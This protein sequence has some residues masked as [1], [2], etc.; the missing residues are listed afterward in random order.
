MSGMTNTASC[1]PARG[2]RG[3]G[4]TLVQV[5]VQVCARSR[6]PTHLLQVLCTEHLRTLVYTRHTAPQGREGK[7]WKNGGEGIKS[8]GFL[9]TLTALSK[10]K[11]SRG[12]H[13]PTHRRAHRVSTSAAGRPH[14]SPQKPLRS[15]ERAL[16][17][18]NRIR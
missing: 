18:P 17:N 10:G 7:E 12:P 4:H 6:Q 2:L 11:N 13:G 14:S 1:R 3:T 15:G 16:A 8:Q 9:H 5:C